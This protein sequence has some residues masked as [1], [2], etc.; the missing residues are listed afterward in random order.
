MHQYYSLEHQY[1]YYMTCNGHCLYITNECRIRGWFNNTC[2]VYTE[3]VINSKWPCPIRLRQEFITYV[4]LLS[5]QAATPAPAARR[6]NSYACR[7]VNP[8][9]ALTTSHCSKWHITRI[10]AKNGVFIICILRRVTRIDFKNSWSLTLRNI[11]GTLCQYMVD[12][13][14]NCTE[15]MLLNQS[16]LIS[17]SC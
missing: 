12:M 5:N 17:R 6:C 10:H 4:A 9:R 15:M 13:Y 7:N 14:V 11:I 1:I 2:S 8:N 3:A 16:Y